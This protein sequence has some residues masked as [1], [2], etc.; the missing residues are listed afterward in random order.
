MNL[1][2]IVFVLISI[3][4]EFVATRRLL[5]KENHCMFGFLKRTKL[6]KDDLKGIS[7]LMYQDVSDDA[8][9]QENLTKE[10]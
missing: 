3:A 9:D 10:I 2:R 4:I 8:W 1:L 6:I 7:K 5:I